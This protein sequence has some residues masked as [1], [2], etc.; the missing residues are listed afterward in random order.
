VVTSGHVTD[1][2]HTSRSATSENPMLHASLVALCF[3]KPESWP[4]EVVHCGN[5]DFLPF[6]LLLSWSWPDDLHIRTWTLAK[7]F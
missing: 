6:M 7:L 3:I 5:R 1:G 4:I 2:G